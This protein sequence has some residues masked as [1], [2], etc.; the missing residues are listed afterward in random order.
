MVR[1]QTNAML[2][3]KQLP[4]VCGICQPLY[5][6]REPQRSSEKTL[7]IF[8]LWTLYICS[9]YF[10]ICFQAVVSLKSFQTIAKPQT[11]CLSVE[12][13]HLETCPIGTRAQKVLLDQPNT[14][15]LSLRCTVDTFSHSAN[16]CTQRASI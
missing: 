1:P 5:F 12:T 7:K 3:A 2:V 14:N 4:W 6:S 9:M 16:G 11:P 8:Y 10:Q 15:D 13:L